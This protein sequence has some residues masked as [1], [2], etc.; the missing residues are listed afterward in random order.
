MKNFFKK[1]F[2][3]D[4]F[5]T[6]IC[7][8]FFL[9]FLLAENNGVALFSKGIVITTLIFSVILILAKK[10]LFKNKKPLF[11][12]VLFFMYMFVF[13]GFLFFASEFYYDEVD[14]NSHIAFTKNIE[15]ANEIQKLDKNILIEK[16]SSDNE[17]GLKLKYGNRDKVILKLAENYKN[18]DTLH[19]IPELIYYD[20]KHPEKYQKKLEKSTERILTKIE[21]V[22]AADV[23]ILN[24]NMNDIIAQVSINL[25]ILRGYDE[26]KIEK[27]IRNLFSYKT[28]LTL[29]INYEIDEKY[30]V[31]WRY[32]DR[33]LDLIKENKNDEANEI[34]KEV[35]TVLGEEKA[36]DLRT[37]IEKNKKWD[38][39]TKK[40]EKDPK[41]Y[42]YYVERGRLVHGKVK[43]EDFQMA[44]FLNPNYEYKDYL[45]FEIAQEYYYHKDYDGAL[46]Y[47]QKIENEK[48]VFPPPNL[49]NEQ[50]KNLAV[51]RTAPAVEPARG[52][53]YWIWGLTY[54]QIIP[55]VYVF[56]KIS[57]NQRQKIRNIKNL[58]SWNDFLSQKN[59]LQYK[60]YK[61][62]EKLKLYEKA[63][64][65]CQKQAEISEQNGENPYYIYESMVNLDFKMKN[66]KQAWSD[67]K[68]K[69]QYLK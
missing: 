57:E 41:N 7:G 69:K 60:I 14:W 67:L 44:L 43:I 22:K 26:K 3:W 2:N 13:A 15:I 9:I 18:N 27:I 16:T 6:F 54:P 66:F 28:D 48:N 50:M 37:E 42:K 1:I 12:Y 68:K 5:F 63:Y 21:G 55:I 20:E 39:L 4:N 47:Y 45:N 46:E 61:C 29:N 17:Y 62:Q 38:E 53:P 23:K 49:I 25:T 19:I 8:F 51:E 58:A 36:Q 24:F 10:F 11:K 64:E 30:Y 52:N 32:K 59:F 35:E 31:Y 56:E 65:T 34:I 33:V 40:I